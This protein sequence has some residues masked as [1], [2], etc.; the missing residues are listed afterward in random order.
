M[1]AESH[2]EGSTAREA[3]ISIPV[4]ICMGFILIN[5]DKKKDEQ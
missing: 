3:V 4:P 1:P 5:V 2:S